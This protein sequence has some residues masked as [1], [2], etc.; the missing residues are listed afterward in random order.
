M[1]VEDTG[2]GMSETARLKLLE[3][4]VLL[5]KKEHEDI[6]G[7]GLG[8]QLCKSMIKKNNGKFDIESELGKGTKMIVSLPKAPPN[9]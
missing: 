4:S 6:I 5:N 7:T 9:G 8:I 3:D 1:V 2:L